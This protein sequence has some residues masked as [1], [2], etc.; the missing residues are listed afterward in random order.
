MSSRLENFSVLISAADS[1]SFA[2]R[3]TTQSRHVSI[4]QTRTTIHPLL[5]E[6]AG[7]EGGRSSDKVNEVFARPHLLSSPPGEETTI[8]S[9]LKIPASLWPSPPSWSS[10]QNRDGN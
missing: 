6:R 2:V 7:G 8:P 1:V 9:A 3:R 5:G 10:L 4:A